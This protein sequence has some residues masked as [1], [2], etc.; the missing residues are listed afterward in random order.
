MYSHL[1]HYILLERFRLLEVFVIKWNRLKSCLFTLS[2]NNMR[3]VKWRIYFHLRGIIR[4][5]G[6]SVVRLF[7]CIRVQNLLRTELFESH[8]MSCHPMGDWSLLSELSLIE[9]LRF[10]V[11]VY[12][13]RDST[14]A[15]TVRS[16]L[17]DVIEDSIQRCM[18]YL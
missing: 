7:Y 18:L 2:F 17:L 8:P 9:S 11:A 14:T 4:L 15:S 10:N 5:C 6:V 13:S 3:E 12:F 16:V 1:H